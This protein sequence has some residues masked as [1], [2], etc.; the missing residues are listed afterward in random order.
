LLAE[1][2]TSIN[3]T[4]HAQIIKQKFC[5]REIIRICS[6]AIRDSF[7]DTTDLFD[8]HDK[9][10][11]D[12]KSLG[13]SKE[14]TESHEDLD[15][16]VMNM[17]VEME[18]GAKEGAI[19]S[20]KSRSP[21]MTEV[22][23]YS[24]GN[25]ILMASKSGAGKT[26]ITTDEAF[27]IIENYPEDVSIQWWLM[28]DIPKNIVRQYI[29]REM[30][31]T[32]KELSNKGYTMSKEEITIAK[33]YQNKLNSYDITFKKGRAHIKTIRNSFYQWKNKLQEKHKGKKH[34][35]I[36]IIDNIKQLMDNDQMNLFRNQTAIDDHI[37]INIKS[38][39][40]ENQEDTLIW[41]LHHLG[42]EQIQ[43]KGAV[44]GYR[45]IE[46]DLKGSESFAAIS[47]QIILLNRPNGFPD[48]LKEYKDDD[49]YETLK[50]LII[51]ECIKNRIIG[52]LGLV[53]RLGSESRYIDDLHLVIN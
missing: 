41:V 33:S 21:F 40:T 13:I 36:L 14:H 3:V 53:Y 4:Y 38:I 35:Y 12:I 11:E 45:P 2:V 47:T 39:S 8:V 5:Q 51:L 26:T 29:G 6:D 16:T 7:E 22:L 15:E 49:R 9:L 27:G 1:T 34:F 31:L 17:F 28:E 44:N 52:T 32:I 50:R 43:S 48:L 23:Q 18:A 24:P 42:K 20:Y 30:G 10:L 37:A 25:I 19:N 46:N